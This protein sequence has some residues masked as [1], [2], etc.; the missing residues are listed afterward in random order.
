MEGLL[1]IIGL[2]I[3]ALAVGNFISQ[4][5]GWIVLGG[6]LII[7]ALISALFNYLDKGR[8]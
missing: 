6:G 1:F 5:L 2:I 3:C 7:L 4:F 8:G